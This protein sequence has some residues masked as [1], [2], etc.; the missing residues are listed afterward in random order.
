MRLSAAPVPAPPSREECSLQGVWRGGRRPCVA[1]P[2]GS[3]G[4]EVSRSEE[5]MNRALLRAPAGHLPPWPPASREPHL[6]RALALRG[7]AR[8][9]ECAK[10][11]WSSGDRIIVLSRPT[12]SQ[13]GCGVSSTRRPAFSFVCSIS[14]LTLLS[15][16]SSLP[17]ASSTHPDLAQIKEIP[18]K[19]RTH[20]PKHPHASEDTLRNWALS[21]LSTLSVRPCKGTPFG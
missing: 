10:T 1:A 21:G 20:T 5:G 19:G 2:I 17:K 18:Q 6:L 3:R 4:G 8:T 12:A 7:P 16:L 11:P 15:P 9:S 14:D 13:P